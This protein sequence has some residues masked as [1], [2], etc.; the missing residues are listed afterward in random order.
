MEQRYAGVFQDHQGGMTHLGRII[1]DAWVFGLLPETQDGAGWTAGQMQALYEQVYAEW[2]KYGHL[3]SRLPDALRER[4]VHIH[5]QAI[6]RA[7]AQGWD[8]EL[9]E[10]D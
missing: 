2:E 10:D 8:P 3:P 6:E 7:R 4:Y 1:R 5:N 9:G